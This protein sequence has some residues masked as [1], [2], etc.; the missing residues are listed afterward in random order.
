M[1]VVIIAGGNVDEKFTGGFIEDFDESSLFIIAC[2]RG[3]EACERIGIKP[4][5]LVGDF[6]S[7]GS[8][9][10]DRAEAAGVQVIRLN[11]VK[12]DTDAEAALDIAIEK[13]TEEDE[14]YLLGATG[15]RL[16]HVLGNISL[17]AKGLKAGRIV[18]MLD[19]H[20]SIQMINPGET[21]VVE[22]GYQFG[23][24]VSVFP[25]MAP[26]K[27]LN[28]KGFKYPVNNGDIEG[29]ST[30]TVSNEL[31]DKEG[32]ITIEEGML[33]VIESRD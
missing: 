8:G 25:Y 18:T 31:V 26:V 11:P 24:Y 15:T 22:E 32:K 29:F 28:M 1:I 21:Y 23:K 20:N 7:A 30:L 12:D 13:T 19:S 6:D 9:V 5:L 16:D 2:D 14:I 10:A 27:G 17:V 4:D 3:Y 33:I